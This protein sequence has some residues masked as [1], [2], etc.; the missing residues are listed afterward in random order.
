MGH[1]PASLALSFHFLCYLKGFPGFSTSDALS[2]EAA[3]AACGDM[4]LCPVEARGNGNLSFSAQ[5]EESFHTVDGQNPCRTTVQKPWNDDSAAS[6]NQQWLQLC[7]QSGAG[8]C[9]PTVV[10]FHSVR[11]A[12]TSDQLKA[13][14]PGRERVGRVGTT[15]KW[16]AC[17]STPKSDVHHFGFNHLQ[18]TFI[19]R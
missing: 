14:S 5:G 7:F 13:K 6:T 10:L 11:L 15:N 17:I 4:L 3:L 19:S 1:C 8:F 9:P 2:L 16:C 12:D 18:F